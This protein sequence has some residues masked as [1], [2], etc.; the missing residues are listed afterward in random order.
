MAS[1][2]DDEVDQVHDLL[3]AKGISY[4]ALKEELLDHMC[5]LIEGM[6]E[7]GTQFSQALNKA[8]DTF[9]PDGIE[10]A[11]EATLYL[12]NLRHRKMKNATSILGMAGGLLTIS[13]TLFKILHY[14]GASIL[15][16]LGLGIIALLFMPMALFVNLKNQKGFRAKSIP[17]SGFIGGIFLILFSLFKIMHW[18]GANALFMAGWTTMIFVFM[19]LRLMKA[20]R[21]AENKWYDVGSLTVLLSGA[22]LLFTLTSFHE[23]NRAYLE[24]VKRVETRA[25]YDYEALTEAIDYQTEQLSSAQPDKANQ[26]RD[27]Q[28]ANALLVASF[29]DYR[30]YL[31]DVD[32]PLPSAYYTATHTESH[33]ASM[34]AY[35]SGADFIEVL[36]SFDQEMRADKLKDYTGLITAYQTLSAEIVGLPDDPARS[37]LS[38]LVQNLTHIPSEKSL[39]ANTNML[40]ISYL[41]VAEHELRNYQKQLLSHL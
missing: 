24:S 9:G 19:P 2:T 18:P 28:T 32:Y 23:Q 14:P 34:T 13:G 27:L 26:L 6:M 21:S 30:N 39:S 8:T 17:I 38:T 5:C 35:T 11:Q 15:L 4:S 16:V 20:Y 33:R 22:V 36:Q 41:N 1:L 12:L 3:V 25:I 29:Y 37:S 40:Y 7:C 31:L 10:R